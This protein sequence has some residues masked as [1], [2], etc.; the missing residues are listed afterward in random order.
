MSK[1]T[2]A[3]APAI[4]PGRERLLEVRLQAG[5]VHWNGARSI[6]HITTDKATKSVSGSHMLIADEL[7]LHPAGCLLRVEGVSWIIPHARVETYRLA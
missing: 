5:S 4:T 7:L 6:T 3:S 1:E 2:A